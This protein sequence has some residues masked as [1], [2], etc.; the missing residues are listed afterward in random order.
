MP[1]HDVKGCTKFAQ[2]AKDNI[3][4]V[5]VTR[6]CAAMGIPRIHMRQNSVSFSRRISAPQS[7]AVAALLGLSL[8]DCRT[9]T[10]LAIAP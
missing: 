8:A 10:D 6:L 4:N 7:E 1:S 3:I 9:E 5:D 2:Y